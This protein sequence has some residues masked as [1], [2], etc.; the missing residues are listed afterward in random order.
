[1][2][3]GSFVLV[4]ICL[5]LSCN[6]SKESTKDSE[7]V[8]YE[9][10]EM[11]LLMRSVYEYNKIT[12]EQII[13]NDSLLSFPEEFLTIHTAILTDPADRDKEFDSLSTE[14]LKTQKATFSSKRDST[15]YYFNKSINLCITCH[16]T[17]CLGPVPKIKKLLIK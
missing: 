4:A 11:A 1:M 3:R 16:E 2:K 14:F 6:Q 7:P 17:R 5:I 13:N 12:K 15:R 9:P 8:M 10:S